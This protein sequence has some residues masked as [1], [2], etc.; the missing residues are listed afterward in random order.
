MSLRASTL[1]AP[2]AAVERHM[3]R[4]VS[5]CSS[6]KYAPSH[7]RCS[8]RLATRCSAICRLISDCYSLISSSFIRYLHLTYPSYLPPSVSPPLASAP[9]IWQELENGDLIVLAPRRRF[10][11]RNRPGRAARRSFIARRSPYRPLSVVKPRFQVNSGALHRS[12]SR[13]GSSQEE[14]LPACSERRAEGPT[15]RDRDR[16]GGGMAHRHCRT[17]TR[18]DCMWLCRRR[19]FPSARGPE[20]KE[21]PCWRL[22]PQ[23]SCRSRA[24]QLQLATMFG[25]ASSGPATLSDE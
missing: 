14:R 25:I 19:G 18:G 7:H 10:C 23:A 1:S 20:A 21:W 9:G 4:H 16:D 12:Y 11:R 3:M 24:V 13:R 2:H 22:Y 5:T 15:T 17:G 8:G 6:A